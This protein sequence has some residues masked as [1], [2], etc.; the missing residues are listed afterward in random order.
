MRCAPDAVRWNSFST[1]LKFDEFASL[2]RLCLTDDF[3]SKE[4]VDRALLLFGKHI[5]SKVG[6]EVDRLENEIR[7]IDSRVQHID[8]ESN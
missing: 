6:D 1:N 8:I 4:A 2:Q 3:S 7:S 5:V